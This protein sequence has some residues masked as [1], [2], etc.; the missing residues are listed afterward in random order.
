M[1]ESM[2]KILI[3][4][5]R[6]DSAEMLKAIIKEGFIETKNS[7]EI[8][9]NKDLLGFNN[10]LKA[11]IS[12][13]EDT[14]QRIKNVIDGI[15]EFTEKKGL[16]Y[17]RPSKSFDDFNSDELYNKSIEVCIKGEDLISQLNDQRKKVKDLEFNKIT[18]T[19]WSSLDLY[20]DQLET[21]ECQAG[22][23]V[24]PEN[25]STDMLDQQISDKEVLLDYLQVYQDQD[26][27]GLRLIYLKRDISKVRE[28]ISTLGGKSLEIN[29]LKGSIQENIKNID[30]EI[31]D[32]NISIE[33]LISEIKG[34]SEHLDLLGATYDKLNFVIQI[35]KEEN[36]T[37][38]S[39]RVNLLTGWIRSEDKP[40]VEKVLGDFRCFAT[41]IK[42]KK[43]EAVPVSLKNPKIIQ[44]FSAITEMYAMPNSR[45]VD[46]NTAIAIFFFL[47]FGMMLS[48][49]GYGLL[50]LIGGLLGAKKLDLSEGG[51]K[52]FTM[53]GYC[54]VSTIFWG[55]LYGSWFGDGIEKFV[56]MFLG[57]NFEMPRLIN[58][59]MEP[60]T[61]L[62]IS[63]IFGIIHI[64]VGMGYKAYLLIRR[65]CLRDAIFDI[66]FWYIVIIGLLLTP[67]TKFG[68]W[69]AGVGA[70]GL[71]LTQGR[72]KPS[73]VG[74]LSSGV[75]SLYNITGYLADILSYSRILAL[76]LATG[77]IAS[78]VSTMGALAGPG[79]VGFIV[80]VVVF[81]FGNALNLAIN[82]LGA[83]VHAARLQYV[84][85]FGKFY[86]SGGKKFKPL[87]IETKYVKIREEQ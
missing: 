22:L 14:K 23:Y 6:E 82:G 49:A 75:L 60:M 77:V 44:P 65:G 2:E 46:V 30:S 87:N 33:S 8:I 4:S 28:I 53:F 48:D 61:I 32:I 84:E 81:L 55:A 13:Q 20:L 54:G 26:S 42:P 43:D 57:I 25:F 85:F 76:G 51:K 15:S 12:E 24:F 83:Y 78:V 80:Y 69:M 39:K 34:L 73:I 9:P 68:L 72:H 31:K 63:C 66:G 10:E 67:V 27:K 79:F 3:Y 19:P 45:S 52:L 86:E 7:E 36:R 47:F 71:V 64:F 1:I 29:N 17:V 38:S 56:N 59:L 74:K 58:P 50:I 41:Y 70:V 18:L 16:F 11:D 5:M 62:A 21:K 40:K 37:L 35:K